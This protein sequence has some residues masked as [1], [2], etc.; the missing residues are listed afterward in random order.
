[1]RMLLRNLKNFFLNI[2]AY[3]I[4]RYYL[5]KPDKRDFLLT[6]L[7]SLKAI[8]KQ[9]INEIFFIASSSRSRYVTS[10]NIE[11]TN[12][13]NLSCVIC[14]G[15]KEGTRQ[16]GMMSMQLFEKI[17]VECG[18]IELVQFSQWGEPLLHPQV[19]M[20]IDYAHRRGIKTFLTTNGILLGN[21]ISLRLL[22][23]GL[24][25]ITFS[26]DGIGSTYNKIRGASYNLLRNNILHF[27]KI[28]DSG[29]FDTKIDISMVVCRDTEGEIGR[30]RT[31]FNTIA[32]R[33]QFIPIF[34]HSKRKAKCRELWRGSL[35][36]FWDGLVTPCCVD[37]EGR[38]V[39]G[40]IQK[41]NIKSIF[42]SSFMQKL[43]YLHARNRFPVPCDTCT[44]HVFGAVSPRFS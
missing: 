32:D 33:I 36:V 2:I 16:K 3:C 21:G 31:E 34:T 28:R 11:A 30:L 40:N 43:R 23:A 8:R 26:V 1:M 6:R 15:Q 37:C 20:M 22:E 12:M 24:D 9:F 14:P 4:T 27:K 17:I 19:Y 35:T 7:W 44:E 13:C 39:V 41:N 25:R 10:L 18:F 38:L 29:G 5:R 42:N